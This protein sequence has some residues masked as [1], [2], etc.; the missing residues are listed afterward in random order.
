MTKSTKTSKKD[1]GSIGF[2]Y[3]GVLKQNTVRLFKSSDNKP[4]SEQESLGTY[5]GTISIRYVNCENYEEVFDQFVEKFSEKHVEHTENV[6][7]ISCSTAADELK[8]ISGAKVAHTLNFEK[9]EKEE[10]EEED[11]DEKPKKGKGKNAK[12]DDEDEK[13]KKGG[14]KVSKKVE[15]EEEQE[16]D[17]EEEQEQEQ[18]EEEEEEEK[19]KKGKG[20]KT[21]KKDEDE[22]D[23]EGEKLQKKS[24]KTSSAKKPAKKAK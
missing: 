2:A 1:Q 18:E 15:E 7:S 11:E 12:K 8:S 19:P 20:K 13:P 16:E 5:Y 24:S 14:K 22:D 23:S 3:G 17:E 10:K 21:S 9:E 6:Y 4:E